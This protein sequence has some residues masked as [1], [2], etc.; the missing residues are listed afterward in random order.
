MKM[1][2]RWIKMQSWLAPLSTGAIALGWLQSFQFVDFASAWSSVLRT[3]FTLLAS[4]LF[5]TDLTSIFL[6]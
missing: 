2:R 3:F 4:S 1:T 5:G 6:T